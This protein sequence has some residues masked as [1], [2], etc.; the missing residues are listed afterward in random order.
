MNDPNLKRSLKVKF[1]AK[2]T[3]LHKLE[4]RPDPQRYPRVA[5]SSDGPPTAPNEG[6]P[7]TFPATLGKVCDPGCH[8][9]GEHGVHFLRLA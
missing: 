9:P 2:R 3:S 8:F 7:Q 6:G 5:A 1:Q 4:G